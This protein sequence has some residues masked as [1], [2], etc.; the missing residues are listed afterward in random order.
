MEGLA[1]AT[2]AVAQVTFY[3]GEDF[4][5]RSFTTQQRVGNFERKG[6]KDGAS[7]VVVV[8]ERWEVC[9]DRRFSGR[10]AILRQGQY[11]SLAAMGLNDRISSVRILSRDA[12][13]DNNR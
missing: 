13:I 3:E 11:P 4:E 2:Q 8:G 1:I 6:F 5:S 9:E 12:N 7:S 10:C